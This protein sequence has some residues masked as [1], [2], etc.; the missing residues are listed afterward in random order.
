MEGLEDGRE[1][2]LASK[3]ACAIGDA[4]VAVENKARIGRT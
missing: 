4:F 2:G 3:A 1:D